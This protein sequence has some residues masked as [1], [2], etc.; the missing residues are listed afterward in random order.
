MSYIR[1]IVPILIVVFGLSANAQPEHSSSGMGREKS[2]SIKASNRRVHDSI[3]GALN[4]DSI[5]TTVGSRRNNYWAFFLEYGGNGGAFSANIDYRFYKHFSI[6]IGIGTIP[7]AQD[8]FASY[9]MVASYV[10]LDSEIHPEIGMGILG[11]FHSPAFERF[12][13]SNAVATGF[14]GIRYQPFIE[15]MFFRLGYTPYFTFTNFFS[16]FGVSL[17]YSF[18]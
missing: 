3:I 11:S 18:N 17:G 4:V 13:S 7:Y 2:D 6:R 1:F 8:W 5:L 15:G 12:G 14:F 9:N 16:Y 10:F